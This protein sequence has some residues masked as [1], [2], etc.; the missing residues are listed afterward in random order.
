[1]AEPTS[2][3][4]LRAEAEDKYAGLPFKAT[5]G[6]LITLR[7]LLRLDDTARKNAQVLLKSVKGSD[8][9]GEDFDAL[10]HQERVLRD[11]FLLVA[12]NTAAMRTEIRTWDLALKVLV[13]DKWMAATQ[14]PEA[15]GSDS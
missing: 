9:E 2:I 5:D 1:M 6:T 14:L 10:A 3:A 15:P 12:D 13:L 8:D 11:L 7:N 4:D